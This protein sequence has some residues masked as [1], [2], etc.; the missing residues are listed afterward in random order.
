MQLLTHALA[1]WC[2]GNLLRTTERERAACMAISLFPDVDGIGLVISQRAYLQWHHVLGHNLLVGLIA[3][4]LLA[5][6]TRSDLRIGVLYL[7]LFHFHLGMDL[8]GSGTGWG[9]EYLW[10]FSSHSFQSSIAWE[11]RSW[12]NYV[13]FFFLAG[14]TIWI[15][16]GRRR[17]PLE[18]LA[19]RLNASLIKGRD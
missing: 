18:F 9:I 16:A 2:V 13:V 4:A 15:A 19:P 11:F 1:G 5:L 12:Q 7:A 17:T 14:A 3:S 6:L 8:V 10:P